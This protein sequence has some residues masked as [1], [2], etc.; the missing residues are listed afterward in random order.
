MIDTT[1]DVEQYDCPFIDTTD[2][3]EVGFSAIQWDFDQ[4]D[5]ELETRMLVEGGD[6]EAVSNGLAALRDHSN[7]HDFDLLTRRGDV[8]H[9][10]TVIAET[11]AMATIRDND[12]YITGPFHIEAGSEIWHVGFDDRTDADTTLSE[13]ERDNEY[14]V[15]D[16]TNTELPEMQDF[17]QNAGAAMTLIEGCR[18][19]SD[20]ERETLETAVSD[21]YFESP[22]GATLGHLADEFDVSKPA[23]SKNLRRGQQ[24]MIERVVE[25]MEELEE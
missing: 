17:V 11:D 9:I 24:K 14:D 21:G 1:L 20:V 25:A 19:L 4:V 6:R 12:G 22:R 23:V 7:M 10:R 15:L 8:A 16:R 18:D 5:R 3:H 2:D 13:L